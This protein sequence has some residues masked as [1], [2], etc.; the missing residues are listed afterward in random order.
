MDEAS[1]RGDIKKVA[2]GAG[3]TLV[4]HG[5]GKG[6]Y[7]LTQILMSRLLGVEAFGLFSLGFAAI[8]ILEVASRLGLHM[9][10]MRF[11]SIY[12]QEDPARLKGTVIT[13]VCASLTSS[14]VLAA[15]FFFLSDSVSVTI[16]HNPELKGVL[17]LFAWS[18]PFSTGVTV[19]ASLLQ[20]FHTTKYT[21]YIRDVIQPAGGI[22]FMILFVSLGFG[23]DGVILAHI[24]SNL[25]AFLVGIYYLFR[26]LAQRSSIRVRAL[27]QVKTLLSYSIPLLFV[28]FLQYLQAW[29]DTLILGMYATPRDVGIYRAAT[30]FPFVMTVFLLATNSVYAPVVAD[31]HA[32]N[33]SQRLGSIYKATTRWVSYVTVP[34]FIIMLL[35]SKELMRL[36]GPDYVEDG[37]L[38]LVILAFGQLINCI[39]GGVS[40]TLSMTGK[41]NISLLFTAI[42]I[43]ANLVLDFLLIPLYGAIGAA[44]ASSASNVAINLCRL[45]C[46]Y[47]I[48]RM[49]PFSLTTGHYM[50][51][52]SILGCF[53]FAMSRYLHWHWQTYYFDALIIV[54]CFAILFHFVKRSE[55]DVYLVKQIAHYASRLRG[56][57]V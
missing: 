34:L 36:F 1:S 57:N 53:L 47:V 42:L 6:L 7:F 44:I 27:Y 4:G 19:T 35:S 41:Q 8:K 22:L 17:Q 30:Q 13:S 38:P 50:G 29:S 18:L 14:V 21:V 32:K 20:G 12:R 48:Y 16:F 45:G 26:F 5:A 2:K 3:L 51:I 40:L 28:G 46:V 52:M 56:A 11:V 23:L 49:H 54:S 55:E 24:L 43:G 33:E 15:L 9:G 37:S 25:L 10:G 31:L 39:T